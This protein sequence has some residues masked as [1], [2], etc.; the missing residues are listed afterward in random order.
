VNASW[1]QEELAA[2]VADYLSMLLAEL[3]GQAV[4]TSAHRRALFGKL[5]GRTEAAVEFK[6]ANISA[7]L[8]ELGLPYIKGYHPSQLPT[9]PLAPRERDSGR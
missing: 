5:N 3:S 8:L 2:T 6:D 4:N 1:S 7:A 9:Q